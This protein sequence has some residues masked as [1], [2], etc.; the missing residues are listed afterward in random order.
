MPLARRL[1]AFTYSPPSPD[2]YLETLCRPLVPL[3]EPRRSCRPCAG[4]GDCFAPDA[5]FLT[6]LWSHH[7]LNFKG[8]PEISCNYSLKSDSGALSPRCRHLSHRPHALS[9]HDFASLSAS[10]VPAKLS[11]VTVCSAR[12]YRPSGPINRL[13]LLSKHGLSSMT[14]I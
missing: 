8:Q 12:S 13:L 7:Q 11:S 6:R 1:L 5:G 4:R 14:M 2:L 3:I 10:K 9:L